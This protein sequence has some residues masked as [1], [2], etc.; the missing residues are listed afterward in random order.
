MFKQ[1]TYIKDV[2]GQPYLGVKFTLEEVED[3][4]NTWKSTFNI[5]LATEKE[6]LLSFIQ[7]KFRRDGDEYHITL[8]NVMELNQ[9]KGSI[10]IADLESKL[11]SETVN[12]IS[13]E[14]IGK[15]VKGSNE[16]HFIVVKSNHL[17]FLREALKLDR[18]D[19]HITL[20]FDSKDVF[21]ISKGIDTIFKEL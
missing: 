1:I 15:A 11:F 4:I 17:N 19:L 3:I 13:F 12:D 8:I 18:K 20:G 16:A 7:N 9:L 5:M 14:G 6:K 10:N 2:T 21:G